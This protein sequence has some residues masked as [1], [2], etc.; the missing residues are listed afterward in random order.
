M[1]PNLHWF[2]EDVPLSKMATTLVALANSL[3]GKLLLGI[4]PRSGQIQGLRDPEL[5]MDRVFQACLLVE[6]TLI[7]PLPLVQEIEGEQILHITVPDGLP[8]VYNFEGRYLWREGSQNNPIPPRRLRQLLLERGVVQFEFALSS[9][10][11]AGR[12]GQRSDP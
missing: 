4:A 10:G 12:P 11:Q 3:G 5:A 8:N 6:P 7:L 2:P 9:R 1:G